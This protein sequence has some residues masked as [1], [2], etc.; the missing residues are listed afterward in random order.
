[1]KKAWW[2]KKTICGDSVQGE[3]LRTGSSEIP[4]DHSSLLAFILLI[5]SLYNKAAATGYQWAWFGE[6]VRRKRKTVVGI[7]NLSIE[8][9][10]RYWK[11]KPNGSTSKENSRNVFVNKKKEESF[12]N[13]K[14]NTHW[15]DFL[16]HLTTF[17]RE[18]K[19]D[20]A[21]TLKKRT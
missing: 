9:F 7:S 20:A 3:S 17:V 12:R 16:V 21:W 4:G 15:T 19:K 10:L 8:Y 13:R 11:S 6:M 2:R 14:G 5:K 18:R 1:M